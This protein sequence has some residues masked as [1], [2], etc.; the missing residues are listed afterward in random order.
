MRPL[1]VI[2]G[3]TNVGKSTL[4]N[5][6]V[7][8][9]QVITS[10][11]PGTTRDRICEKVNW[12]GFVFDL[13]DT[14][15]IFLDAHQEEKGYFLSVGYETDIV[16][17]AYET[18]KIADLIL[19]LVDIQTGLLPEDKKV[20][21]MIR[22]Q[23]KP[24]ILVANKADNQQWRQEAENLRQLG[25]GK[26]IAIS[27]LHGIGT[28]DL[29]DEIVN[30]LRNTK[31]YKTETTKE[32][33]PK[34]AII[35]RPNVGKSSLFNKLAGEARA[36]VSDIPGTT[37]DVI[38]SE[39]IINNKKYLFLDT[40]GLRRRRKIKK[41]IEY[42]SVLRALRAIE[43]ADIILFIIDAGEGIARQDMR[44]ISQVVEKGKG[45]I[46]IINKWDLLKLKASNLEHKAIN[47]YLGYLQ[48]KLPFLSWVPVIF[49]SA[50]TGKNVYKIPKLIDQLIAERKKRIKIKE[51][52]NLI[53]EKIIQNPPPRTKQGEAKIYYITQ[54]DSSCPTFVIMVN[55]KDLLKKSYLNY[56]EN[57]IR[58]KY[59]FAGTP[60]RLI[61]K[62]KSTH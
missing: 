27:A 2:I 5:R 11:M 43:E 8:K 29:L 51:L 22:K 7:G 53:K 57:A 39:V 16:K 49:I 33:I 36:I 17:Q 56:L 37:R 10:E 3:R 46:L 45:L 48:E 25:L 35:G 23:N 6:L 21:N 13:V 19:L 42:F 61:L 28:G 14:G 1:V 26:P 62:S 47:D 38:N 20:I 18:I 30:V 60:I 58:K 40:A 50:K 31:I 12:C 9:H 59:Q 24:I 54:I 44:I 52:N 55:K 15:G 4:F 41:Q 34:I 32:D